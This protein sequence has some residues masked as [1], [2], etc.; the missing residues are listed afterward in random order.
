[1]IIILSN[2]QLNE[3]RKSHGIIF[4]ENRAKTLEISKFNK[5][6]VINIIGHPH[7]KSFDNENDW[8]YFERV[9]VKG[10][11]HK[12]GKNILKSNN[13]LY[14][15]FDKYGIL[16]SKNFLS[17]DDLQKMN[18]SEKITE[19]DLSKRSFVESFF[20]SLKNKMYGRK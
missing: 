16:S 11:F 20:S 13:I 4:L 15:Q 3:T 12:L 18:F 1:M 6:D 7:T 2:C 10:K 8:I 17:K 5:N 19:N 14:L 9:F